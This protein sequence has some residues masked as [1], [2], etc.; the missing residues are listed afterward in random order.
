MS[1]SETRPRRRLAIALAAGAGVANVIVLPVAKVWGDPS[2]VHS[3]PSS[4]PEAGAGAGPASGSDAEGGRLETRVEAPD[5]LAD[6]AVETAHLRALETP[7]SVTIA[8]VSPAVPVVEGSASHAATQSPA[9]TQSSAGTDSSA[10]TSSSAGTDLG[11][12]TITCYD[13]RGHTADGDQA[14]PESAAV[15]PSVI[16]LG[17]RLYIDGVGFRT[18]DDTGGDVQGRHVD[19]WEPTYSDCAQWGVQLRDVRRVS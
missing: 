5:G 15:D 18:A 10:G 12:F 6:I 4:N 19:I 16:P 17:T 9:A 8:S 3:A 14:G 13:L 1:R 7:G 11:E 2:P